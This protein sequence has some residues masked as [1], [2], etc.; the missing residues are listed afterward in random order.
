M[1]RIFGLL[2]VLALGAP[3][4]AQDGTP[5]PPMD[6]YGHWD[7]YDGAGN[8]TG[9]DASFTQVAPGVYGGTSYYYNDD[10]EQ[11]IIDTSTFWEIFPGVYYYENSQGKTGL[12]GWDGEKYVKTSS[13]PIE[14]SLRPPC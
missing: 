10:G 8:D 3:M 7:I 9:Y 2:I 4:F 6:A 14:R 13:N 5:P 1:P 11:V 12:F